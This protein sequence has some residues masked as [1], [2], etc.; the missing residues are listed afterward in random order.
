M[1]L[2]LLNKAIIIKVLKYITITLLFII[3]FFYLLLDYLFSGLCGNTII[4]TSTSPN[5]KY[6]L[7]LYQ[8]DCGA[9]TGFSSQI[10]LLD[11][12][13]KLDL[14][15]DSGNIYIAK[16]YPDN[17]EIIWLSNNSVLIKRT[18]TETYKMK[19]KFSGISFKYVRLDYNESTQ[20]STSSK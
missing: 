4:Q 2:N 18:L 14:E 1:L 19:K 17:F 3:L 15:D 7:V 11:I 13:K 8:R 9:T 10:S 20:T 16:G 5:Q 6:K 12:D